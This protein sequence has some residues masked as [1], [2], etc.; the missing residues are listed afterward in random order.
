MQLSCYTPKVVTD[1]TIIS[2]YYSDTF[3]FDCIITCPH[4]PFGEKFL[5]QISDIKHLIKLSKHD[6][7]RYLSIEY[8]FG[9]HE[10]G[11][12]IARYCWDKL[13]IKVLIVEPTLPRA[14]IDP[15]RFY[16]HCVR[17]V[18]DYQKYPEIKAILVDTHEQYIYSLKTIISKA[19]QLGAISIDLH[20]MAPYSPKESL[21]N[22]K[23]ILLETPDNL[24]DYIESFE[25]SHLN[26]EIRQTEIF[27]GDLLN[28][29]YANKDVI[30][31]LTTNF[32][33]A[34]IPISYDKPYLLETHMVGYY[35]M[36]ELGTVCI[37][38][39]KDLLSC[40]EITD[41]DFKLSNLSVDNT[42]VQILASCFSRAIDSALK[43]K[44]TIV[45]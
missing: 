28:N 45:L 14:I 24:L 17:N 8:D 1:N 39:R 26:G 32:N 22:P 2:T 23:G 5:D 18:I 34:N 42:K 36:L 31:A 37:D 40:N 33:Q 12:A 29:I 10:L 38:V 11:H 44:E 21:K 3:D 43:V 6:F 4:A 7:Q 13:D 16:P 15:G 25:L 30:D 35:L 20:S 19:K 41:D 27:T 9:T